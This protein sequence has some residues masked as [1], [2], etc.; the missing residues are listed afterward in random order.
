MR[1]PLDCLVDWDAVGRQTLAQIPES[2]RNV[3]VNWIS[4]DPTI[5]KLYEDTLG[6]DVVPLWFV[7][8]ARLET[9]GLRLPEGF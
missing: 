9:N 2:E 7:S 6:E 5:L 1:S 3:F 8:V 4:D